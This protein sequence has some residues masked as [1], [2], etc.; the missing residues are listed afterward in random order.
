MNEVV[1]SKVPVRSKQMEDKHYVT[2]AIDSQKVR[3][4]LNTTSDITLIT[5]KTR[6]NM[7]I[8]GTMSNILVK[9][10]TEQTRYFYFLNMNYIEKNI[11]K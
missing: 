5:R 8:C 4:Q 9:N 2:L 7:G 6:D 10:E 1:S 3:L 11:N